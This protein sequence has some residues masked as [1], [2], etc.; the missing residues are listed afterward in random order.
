MSS[1]SG[2]PVLVVGAV[3]DA[4]SSANDGGCSSIHPLANVHADAAG[5]SRA[6]PSGQPCVH[7]TTRTRN[8]HQS[9]EV[10][11]V[12]AAY[13]PTVS[14]RAV[15][16]ETV[17]PLVRAVVQGVS[18]C[19]L[20][21]G[22][23][24]TAA[25]H[26]FDATPGLDGGA[27]AFVAASL[28]TELNSRGVAASASGAPGG[29][30]FGARVLVSAVAIADSGPT[31]LDLLSPA[32]FPA[33]GPVLAAYGGGADGGGGG[34]GP[35]SVIN[36]DFEGAIVAGALAYGPVESA[37]A[38]CDLLRA[39]MTSYSAVSTNAGIGR[40][41][42]MGG[43]GTMRSATGAPRS[44]PQCLASCVSSFHRRSVR[45]ALQH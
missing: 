21:T 23:C 38:L 17:T 19:L 36:D 43:G 12:D 3:V 8:S 40:S 33:S 7:V 6:G 42:V 5:A 1:T 20:V 31:L 32:Q 2:T 25:R 27:L 9:T 4:L 34:G 18:A 30:A 39:A 24:E 11:D 44:I 14:A 35:L 45:R 29:A 15:L 22:N 16:G 37:A 26:W 28:F 41:R 10:I 13:A